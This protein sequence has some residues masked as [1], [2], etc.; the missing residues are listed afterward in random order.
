MYAPTCIWTVARDTFTPLPSA[1]SPAPPLAPL[2]PMT[3]A[4]EPTGV[5]EVGPPSLP[6]GGGEDSPPLATV[7][8]AAAE[9]ADDSL[10]V[11]E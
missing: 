2:A 9:V 8:P 1:L 4:S 3:A 7:A 11:L 5:G 10:A 6:R